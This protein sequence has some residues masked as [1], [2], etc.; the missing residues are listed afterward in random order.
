MTTDGQIKR[1]KK[2][3]STVTNPGVGNWT[4]I[5]DTENADTPTFVLGTAAD[6]P[7]AIPVTNAPIVINPAPPIVG[8]EDDYNAASDPLF[9]SS[10]L[11]V[12]TAAAPQDVTGLDATGVIATGIIK[13]LVNLGV[14]AITIKHNDAGVNSALTNQVLVAGAADLVMNPGA[15]V[16]FWYDLAATAWR[17]V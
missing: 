15:A 5:V 6:P 8:Q 11:V 14:A 16:D 13:K 10:T 2:G 9:A 7:I 17:T 12:V 1:P 3:L 4:E